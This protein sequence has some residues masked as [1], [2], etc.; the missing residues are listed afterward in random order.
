MQTKLVINNIIRIIRG[1]KRITYLLLFALI[2]NP[3]SH[4]LQNIIGLG[5][6]YWL[7]YFIWLILFLGSL[8]LKNK[9]DKTGVF[10]L[11]LL[12]INSFLPI[13]SGD[14][15]NAISSEIHKA[16]LVWVAFCF[17]MCMR[18][19]PLSQSNII[20]IYR[21]IAGIG[22]LSCIY[23]MI[24]QSTAFLSVLRGFDTN[25]NSWSYFS[26]YRQRNIFGE[27]CFLSTIASLYLYLEKKSKIFLVLISLNLLQIFITD[28]RAALLASLLLIII[29]FYIPS[30]NKPRFLI[31]AFSTLI[32]VILLMGGIE[33][34][35]ERFSHET[36][37]IGEEMDSGRI[38]MIMWNACIN[39]LIENDGWIWGFGIGSVPNFLEPLFDLGSTHSGY[40]DSL[41]DG[42]ILLLIITSVPLIYSFKALKHNVDVIYKNVHIGALIS[43]FLYNFM[44]AGMALFSSNFFSVTSTLLLIMIPLNYRG[45]IVR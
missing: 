17:A 14:P 34:I 11:Y 27:Y 32:G 30:K 35:I 20:L 7:S 39:Y 43:F 10:L 8:L 5:N 21:V 15:F 4:F 1:N 3:F 19:S 45:K 44:E 9:L 6:T 23:A 13:F 24:F 38:R 31:F 28:S 22:A 12:V 26:F 36:H 18:F 37:Q 42:G 33:G 41:F 16:I 25:V 2:L 40:F 29:T